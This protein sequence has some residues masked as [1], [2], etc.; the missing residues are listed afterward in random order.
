MSLNVAFLD[1]K[2]HL[3]KLS[4]GKKYQKQSDWSKSN[5]LINLLIQAYFL[6]LNSN[7]SKPSIFAPLVTLI[8]LLLGVIA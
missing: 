8:I 4:L 2:N 6:S 5:V 7:V 1:L 3:I